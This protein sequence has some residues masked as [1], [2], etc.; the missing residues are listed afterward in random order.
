[1]NITSLIFPFF[2]KRLK[3]IETRYANPAE[4]Q[5]I[6]LQRLIDRAK[7]TEWGKKYEYDQI[8][9]YEDFAQRVPIQ[10]YEEVKP[11]VKRMLDGEKN[12]LWPSKIE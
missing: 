2:E 9:K 6:Q 1:M 8:T 10:S 4:L 7:R 3:K 5:Q 11:Y 12:L